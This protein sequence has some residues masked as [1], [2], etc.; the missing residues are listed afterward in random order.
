LP[1]QKSDVTIAVKISSAKPEVE[2]RVH[3]NIID[4]KYSKIHPICQGGS[5]IPGKA[6]LQAVA[7]TGLRAWIGDCVLHAGAGPFCMKP[8]ATR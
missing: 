1:H 3:R 5:Q 6:R 7:S 8:V 2:Y 4:G